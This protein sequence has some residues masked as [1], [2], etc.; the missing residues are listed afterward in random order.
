M[1]F[2]RLSTLS[3]LLAAIS[4]SQPA[5]AALNAVAAE[6]SYG[7]MVESIGG[8]HVEVISLLDSPEVNPHAFRADPQIARDLQNADLVVIN[9]LG[10]D[11]WMEPLLES[12]DSDSR[13]VIRASDAGSHRVMADDNPHLFYSPRL[14][15]ATASRVASALTSLDPD[16]ADDYRANLTS[17]QQELMPVYAAVQGLI[18]AYPDLSVTATVPVY[19]YM[20]ELL[21]YKNRFHDIQ[22]AS[23][24]NRQPSARQVAAFSQALEAREVDLLIYN[25]QVHSRLTQN[26]VE[27]A[28]SA[29]LPVVGVSAIP[30]HGEN[31]AEWQIRQLDAIHQA[32]DQAAERDTRG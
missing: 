10:F 9:G 12:T 7:S 20:I 19:S 25:Q 17:F 21:G 2:P 29:G 11:G 13:Q 26:Q 5:S 6:S 1:S 3:L 24:G 22:F 30:M 27:T 14:M 31:Y 16:N 28:R 8:D 15:L 18:A 23:M 32:L 4:V